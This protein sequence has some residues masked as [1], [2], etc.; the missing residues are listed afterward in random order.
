M[1][2]RSCLCDS[3]SFPQFLREAVATAVPSAERRCDCDCLCRVP[4]SDAEHKLIQAGKL[5]VL[6]GRCYKEGR[7]PL[8][9]GD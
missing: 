6:C 5:R 7:L 9:W 3:M 8:P 1:P 4:L 2:R